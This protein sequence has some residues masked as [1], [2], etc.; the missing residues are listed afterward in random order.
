MTQQY[1]GKNQSGKHKELSLMETQNQ[2]RSIDKRMTL[3]VDPVQ[4]LRP[5][6]SNKCLKRINKPLRALLTA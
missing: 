4:Q 3:C 2:N 6:Q 1:L 5:R